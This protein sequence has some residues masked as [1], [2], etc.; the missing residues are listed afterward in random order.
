MIRLMPAGLALDV[1]AS[2]F[3]TGRWRFLVGVHL[4]KMLPLLFLWSILGLNKEKGGECHACWRKFN[5]R[6]DLE[7]N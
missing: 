1:L 7:V 2:T 6:R 4:I 3:T 5:K